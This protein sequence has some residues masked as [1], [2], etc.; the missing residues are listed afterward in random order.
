M[1]T[2]LKFL[3]QK[4]DN[5]VIFLA[6]QEAIKHAQRTFKWEED[7]EEK[8]FKDYYPVVLKKVKAN[9]DGVD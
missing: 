2:I 7:C 4:E 5:K 3:S 9:Q 6:M 1:D 8:E